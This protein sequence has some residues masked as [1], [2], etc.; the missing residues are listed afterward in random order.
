MLLR[1]QHVHR[2][3][4]ERRVG[5]PAVAVVIR[6]LLGLH[7]QVH[8]VGPEKL[9][10]VEF[11]RLEQVEHLQDGETLRGRRR[12]PEREVAV[13]AADRLAPGRLL[14][15]EVQRGEEAAPLLREAGELRAD[16]ALVEAGPP[17]AADRFEGAG[18]VGVDQLRPRPRQAPAGDE[19]RGCFRVRGEVGRRF[20]D[21]AGQ[22]RG[23]RETVPRI[24]DRRFQAARQRQATERGVRRAPTR[25]RAGRGHRRRQDAA[26]RNLGVPVFAE[27]VD[28]CGRRRAPAA[29]QV[30]QRRRS[31]ASW[32]SQ[33]ASPQPR[34]VRMEH[35]QRGAGGDRRIHRAAAGAQHVDAGLRGGVR[36]GT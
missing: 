8:V 19:D 29:V 25:D 28:V 17:V 20:R 15:G 26:K 22:A 9:L 11:Q 24:T 5:E 35:R 2:D 23:H 12:L 4:G 3:P 1:D 14:R 32:I 10:L 27:P 30:P 31:S 16:G 36:A 7:H 21:P 34:H 6:D 33:N 13:R 18:Q